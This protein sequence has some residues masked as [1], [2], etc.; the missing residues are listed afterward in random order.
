MQSLPGT[1]LPHLDFCALA[2]AQGVAARRADTAEALDEAL[3]WSFA[4]D[5]PSLVEAVVD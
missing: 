4:A 1:Q 2:Q 3:K 5:V